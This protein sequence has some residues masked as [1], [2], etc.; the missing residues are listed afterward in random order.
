MLG[1]TRREV[2]A[3]VTTWDSAIGAAGEAGSGTFDGRAGRLLATADV[4]DPRADEAVPLAFA[5]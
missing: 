5:V 2:P 4:R 3:A 1:V